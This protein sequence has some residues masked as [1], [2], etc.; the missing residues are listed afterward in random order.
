MAHNNNIGRITTGNVAPKGTGANLS[1]TTD[2]GSLL[3]LRYIKDDSPGGASGTGIA[4][5]NIGSAAIKTWFEQYVGTLGN[6]QTFGTGASNIKWSDY[7]GATILGMKLK[8]KNESTSRYQDNDDA[9]LQITPL[10]GN[11]TNGTYTITVGGATV[12]SSGNRGTTYTS[13]GFGSGLTI[14]VV[15]IDNATGVSM[16][17]SWT[18]AYNAGSTSIRGS[19]TVAGPQFQWFF[20]GASGSAYN[21]NPLYFFSGLQNANRLYGEG[22]PASG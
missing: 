10:N 1:T 16:T 14:P 15:L 5:T 11:G 8:A 17:M 4:P 9:K 20:T 18:T 22:Y 3:G 19:A 2:S 12:T 7:R 21:A 13:A 6:Y